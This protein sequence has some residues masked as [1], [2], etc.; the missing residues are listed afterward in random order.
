M[1]LLLSAYLAR[2]GV[3]A[4]GLLRFPYVT[5][6]KVVSEQ[7]TIRRLVDVTEQVCSLFMLRH[8]FA[9]SG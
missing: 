3:A 1:Y 9:E 2:S 7:F 8:E 5:K 6:E 4:R